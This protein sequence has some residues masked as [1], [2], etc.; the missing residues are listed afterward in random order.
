[1][2]P[3]RDRRLRVFLADDSAMVREKLRSLFSALPVVEVCGEAASIRESITGIDTTAADAVILDAD[4]QDGKGL[5]VIRA[6]KARAGAPIVIILTIHPF[7]EMGQHY[8]NA[9]ADHYYEKGG[10]LEG[11]LLLLESLGQNCRLTR[12][13]A[14][15]VNQS[16]SVSGQPR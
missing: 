9:G 3:L 15:P 4:L 16:G 7:E 12:P 11:L 6:V 10:S 1:M 8:L 13:D 14:V 2:S 5:D